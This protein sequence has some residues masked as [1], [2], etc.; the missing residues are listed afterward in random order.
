MRSTPLQDRAERDEVGVDVDVRPFDGE[1]DA[2]LRCKVGNGFWPDIRE[3]GGRRRTVCQVLSNE[4]EALVG[5]Q[6][7][8][9]RMLQTNVVVVVEIVNSDDLVTTGQQR[10]G[11]MHADEPGNPRQ[12]YAHVRISFPPVVMNDPSNRPAVRGH[13]ESVPTMT[14]QAPRAPKPDAGQ[15]SGSS[16]TL[17]FEQ[18]TPCRWR[19]GSRSRSRYIDHQRTAGRAQREDHPR[20]L[21]ELEVGRDQGYDHDST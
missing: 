7:G 10:L 19:F 20:C 5:L 3:E 2:G 12:K 8:Q 17:A 9:P 1:T 16:T 6:P 18:G 4:A 15:R 11:N 13:A 14:T 21:M